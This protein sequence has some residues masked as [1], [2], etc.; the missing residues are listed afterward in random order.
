MIIDAEGSQAELYSAIVKADRA[1]ATA[2]LAAASGTFGYK[3]T[4]NEILEPC[5]RYVGERFVKDR[6]SLAQGYVAGKVAEDLLER[7]ESEN[8]PLALTSDKRKSAVIGNAEDDF[9]AIGRKMV[10]TFLMIEGWKVIDLGNDVLAE[11][12]V[13]AALEAEASV[14][15]VSAMMLTNA[16]NISKVRD[17]IGRRGLDGR[18]SLAVGGAV[19][20]MRPELVREVGGDG[21]AQTALEAAG[22]FD[23]LILRTGSPK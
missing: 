17:E 2:I 21:T 3:A 22:L 12:F 6:L 18:I 10:G 5:L 13:D 23:R 11:A 9:H 20:V 19:F 8:G 4:I 15:G 7:I 14:I 16:R 1:E